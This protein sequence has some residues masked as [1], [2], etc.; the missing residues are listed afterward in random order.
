[1]LYDAG[2][3]T[4]CRLENVAAAGRMPVEQLVPVDAAYFGE[5]TVG[6]RR[7]Y[8]AQGVNERVDL[9]IRSHRMPAARIGMYA[10]LSQSE[11]DG[12]YRIGFAQPVLD[13]HNLKATDLTLT[14]LEQNYELAAKA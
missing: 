13:D 1:M 14:R 3:V 2:L 11:N 10:V 12:Q 9:L 5:R 6:Y 4:L 7:F 8:A